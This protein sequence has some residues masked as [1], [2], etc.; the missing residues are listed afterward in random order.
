MNQNQNSNQPSKELRSKH[1][2]SSTEANYDNADTP[3]VMR[4]EDPDLE[5]KLD[6]IF[7]PPPC[8]PDTKAMDDF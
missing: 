3:S 2:E 5:A 1:S 4:E 7:E 8:S 6:V